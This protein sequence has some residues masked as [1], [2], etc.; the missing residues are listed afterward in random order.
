M[1]YQVDISDAKTFFRKII[2]ENIPTA[3]LNWIDG[4]V[5]NLEDDFK[6]RSFYMAFSTVPRYISKDFLVMTKDQIREA[7]NLRQGFQPKY[8][9]QVQ[10][11]RTYLLLML[12]ND[13]AGEYIA[14]LDKLYETADMDEQI[15]L[16]GALPLLPYPE[17][18]IKRAADGIRTNIT[19]VFDAI[20]LHNPYPKE[21]LHEEAWN[22]MVLKAVFMQR[23]LYRIY[24]ADE[25][26]NPEL[27]R[28]LIDFAH[29]R[30]AAGRKV[31][32]ELWRFVAPY[33]GNN[34]LS[35]LTSLLNGDILERK[36]ALLACAF[37]KASQAEQLLNQFPDINKEILS[38]SLDWDTLG[39]LVED[40]VLNA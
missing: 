32:P 14:S 35:D 11:V 21:F 22:Q 28:M 31:W 19:A 9:N 7:E 10:F 40:N 36:A 27:A 18:L 1:I 37:S 13:I 29:E 12:P 17:M 30:R 26:T 6:I 16:F 38:G 23:P 8:W 5:S 2:Q 4:Q 24:R 3:G 15:S 25:R 20:T 34:D 33:M 39:E